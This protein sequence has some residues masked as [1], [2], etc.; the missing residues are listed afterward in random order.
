MKLRKHFFMQVCT[1]IISVSMLLA[2][3][4]AKSG[5]S[6]NT[7][8]NTSN[9]SATSTTQAMEK[10]P[11]AL[12]ISEPGTVTL[13][14]IV[15]ENS[16][17][18]P[19]RSSE[20]PVIKEIERLTGINLEVEAIPES[21]YKTVISTR[22][23]ANSDLPDILRMD[24]S[25]YEYG[26]QGI[27]VSLT[28]FIEKY[29]TYLEEYFKYEPESKKYFIS[30]DGNYYGWYNVKSG[31]DLADP[32]GWIIRKD[33]LDNLKLE[34]PK[35]VD[36]WYQV[37]KAFKEQDPNKNGKSD[38]IPWCNPELAGQTVWGHAWGLMML[39]SEGWSINENGKVELDWIK[40]EAKEMFTWLNK[41]FSE[42]LIDPE[43]LSMDHKARFSQNVVGG[44]SR[45]ANTTESRAVLAR[46]G[47][48]PN[49]VYV[50]LPVPMGPNGKQ[51]FMDSYGP[52]DNGS[53]VA[54]TNKCKNPDVAFRFCDWLWG[55]EQGNRLMWFG[56]EGEHYKVNAKG[57]PE[58]TDYILKNP[59][60]Y[61]PTTALQVIGGHE[62]FSSIRSI[63]GTWGAWAKMQL[64]SYNEN[65]RNSALIMAPYI[66]QKFPVL[67]S[68]QEEESE[69][70]L[71]WND[72]KTYYEEQAVG[73]IVGDSTL[74]Q[75]DTYVNTIKKIG[76]DKVIAIKQKQYDRMMNQK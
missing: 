64:A 46:K 26:K 39:R 5:S 54:I 29:D 23:A 20:L 66:G 16:S 44:Y 9:S 31:T 67:V 32:Y 35:T 52:A 49:A 48:D 73:F 50:G 55:S 70:S 69:L 75:W 11:Y 38:E 36:D 42:G 61:N 72:I 6:E 60:G 59:D 18:L 1:A 27:L 10:D 30:P 33:W 37:M 24:G 53:G 22:L 25:H 57:E 43:F 47:G 34:S 71:Y 74:D 12:P 41:C 2:G 45:F 14:Y 63:E 4:N 76:L 8:Q 58:Y 17:G 28:P 21:Q 40:P 15:A 19:S 62:F 3:C 13:K 7:A 51:G 56:I 65:T 68:E